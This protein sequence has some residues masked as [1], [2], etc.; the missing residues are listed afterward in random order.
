MPHV[1]TITGGREMT[2]PNNLIKE[3]QDL[4]NSYNKGYQDGL[5]DFNGQIDNLKSS[6]KAH[7]I[8]NVLLSLVIATVTAFT[9]MK[10]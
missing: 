7:I 6:C 8:V 2:T 9:V 1:P 10:G 4:K 3:I 5:H